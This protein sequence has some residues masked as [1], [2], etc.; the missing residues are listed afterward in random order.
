MVMGIRTLGTSGPRQGRTWAGSEHKGRFWGARNV[1]DL[2]GGHRGVD[3]C[4]A[5]PAVCVTV[6]AFD[7]VWLMSQWKKPQ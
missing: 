5:S 4:K 7:C 3:A 6:H 1:L 2:G